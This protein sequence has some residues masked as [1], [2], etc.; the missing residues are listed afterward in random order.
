MELV[1]KINLLVD[2]I[3]ESKESI[4]TEEATK[5]S[6]IL[7]FFQN[8]G[9]DVFNPNIFVPEFT[10]DIG[11]K[12]HEKVDYAI[13]KDNKPF[14]L[15]E[16]KHHAQKL[17]NHHN[18]LIRY[19]N[20]VDCKFAVLTNG[21]EYRFFSDLDKENI[22]DKAPFLTINLLDLKERDI[23]EIEKFTADNIDSD[24]ILKL[25]NKRKYISLVKSIFKEEISNP[26]ESLVRFFASQMTDKKLTQNVLSEFKPYIKQAFSEFSY[27][28]ASEKLNN[29]KSELKIKSEESL[30]EEIT[31]LE[32]KIV[33][34]EEEL[35][36]FFIIKSI[37]AEKANLSRIFQRDNQSYFAILLD[38]NNRKWIA[39][40]YFNT[41]QKYLAIHISDKKE[42][43]FPIE[44]V[45]DI[46]KYK[47]ELINTLN[48][49]I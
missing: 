9:F 7:P 18:Q 29:I 41:K 19:F 35:E 44:K 1:S 47:H 8:L 43:K 24:N 6:F 27:D 46:Y 32:N 4:L 26:S 14:I 48:R 23:K 3:Y 33:T 42:E 16:A 11:L 30:N 39:R 37:L 2:R 31:E 45:E 22:M 15:I 38:D 28:L 20:V 40:L 34:T 5:Q 10:A 25:A 36:G 12:K 21:I 17:D 13:F 49:L